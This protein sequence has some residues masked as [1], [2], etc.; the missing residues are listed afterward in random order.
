MTTKHVLKATIPEYIRYYKNLKLGLQ[1]ACLFM[2]ELE[3]DIQKF[4]QSNPTDYRYYNPD[5]QKEYFFSEKDIPE[6]RTIIDGL[7]LEYL[8]MKPEL[9]KLQE[10]A[11]F[12]HLV[13]EGIKWF[14]LQMFAKLDF[15]LSQKSDDEDKKLDILARLFILTEKYETF[16]SGYDKFV[17]DLG[18]KII[19]FCI[20]DNKLSKESNIMVLQRLNKESMDQL[21][22]DKNI[23]RE[24]AKPV[25]DHLL[26]V[27]PKHFSFDG[28]KFNKEIKKSII[29]PFD[30]SHDL[31][32][33][34]VFSLNK[35]NSYYIDI[36]KF[37]FFLQDLDD[38]RIRFE[39]KKLNKNVFDIQYMD[40]F[41][42]MCIRFRSPL[43]Y[44]KV[45]FYFCDFLSKKLL[46]IEELNLNYRFLTY[47][48]ELIEFLNAIHIARLNLHTEIFS[49][50]V[51]SCFSSYEY[52]GEPFYEVPNRREFLKKSK[53][54]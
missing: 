44:E 25:V 32:F 4:S 27:S 13:V 3:L 43:V 17:C 16:Y 6:I 5:T 21:K 36:K 12:E 29:L 40:Q 52:N 49:Y 15:I 42:Q 19:N 54:R 22:Q 18:A 26:T 33:P 9:L 50:Y 35:N 24:I 11:N 46:P 14:D 10:H 48:G 45:K 8:I 34:R 7:A 31:F 53:K 20:S 1:K 41:E 30:F 28:V 39:I 37:Y 38:Y 51:M 23:Q 2:R 47:T